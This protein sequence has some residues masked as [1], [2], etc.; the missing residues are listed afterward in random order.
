MKLFI[1]ESGNTG[2]PLVEGEGL[3]NF[4]EQPFFALAGILIQDQ[5]KQQALEY[6]IDG[7]KSKYRIQATE[8]KSKNI[9][10]TKPK[11]YIELFQGIADLGVPIFWELMDKKY[12][13]CMHITNTFI[14]P[15]PSHPLISDTSIEFQRISAEALYFILADTFL[16]KFSRLCLNPN[17]QEFES[18]F[19]EFIEV[20]SNADGEIGEVLK[21]S[22]ET[23]YE[24]YIRLSKVAS[25]TP[26]FLRFMPLPDTDKKNRTISILPN[27]NAFTNLIARCEKYRSDMGL[28]SFTIIHDEQ[29]HF[30]DIL[31]A[32][33]EVMKSTNADE[34]LEGTLISQ[35]SSYRIHPAVSLSFADSKQY[36]VIQTADLI[37]GFLMR[38]WNDFFLGKFKSFNRYVSIWQYFILPDQ[39]G[40]EQHPSLGAN[41]VIPQSHY[42]LLISHLHKF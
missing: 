14:L 24:D 12:Y 33:F 11:L 4:Q 13:L 3:S 1:D 2:Q 32:N 22:A 40:H 15:A 29:K 36:K 19:K 25:G 18:T 42:Q 31:T 28:D 41:M 37:A 9:Y 23:A 5:P 6:L 26:A 7:L 17:K 39:P 8:L 27:T 10:E 34:L 38:S 21:S 30:D 35:K 20:V 16:T